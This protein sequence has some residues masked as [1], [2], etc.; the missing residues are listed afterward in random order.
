MQVQVRKATSSGSR[1]RG[2]NGSTMYGG[3]LKGLSPA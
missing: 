1:P 2:T 3:L